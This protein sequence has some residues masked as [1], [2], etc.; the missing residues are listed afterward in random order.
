LER[1]QFTQSLLQST[2]EQY[3]PFGT[4]EKIRLVVNAKVVFVIS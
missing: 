1:L 3:P 4:A 2:A